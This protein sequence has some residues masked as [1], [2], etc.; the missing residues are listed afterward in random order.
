MDKDNS[1]NYN[2]FPAEKVLKMWYLRN[3]GYTN[4]K[5]PFLLLVLITRREGNLGAVER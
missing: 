3:C 5:A 1:L 4:V 2:S